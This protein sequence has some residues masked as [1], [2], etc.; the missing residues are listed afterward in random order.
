MIEL[1]DF[2]QN[3]KTLLHPE[4]FILHKPQRVQIDVGKPTFDKTALMSVQAPDM[5]TFVKEDYRDV[6]ALIH[7]EFHNFIELSHAMTGTKFFFC[8]RFFQFIDKNTDSLNKTYHRSHVTM[9][10]L[11]NLLL[12]VPIKESWQELVK[13]LDDIQCNTK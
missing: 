5:V 1:T 3:I 10:S 12:T 8:P 13:L 2:D 9:V 7:L 4:H 6:K 11:W